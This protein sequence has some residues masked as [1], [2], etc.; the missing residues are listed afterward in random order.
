MKNIYPHSILIILCEIIFLTIDILCV[1]GIVLAI[2]EFF[3][4]YD[5]YYVLIFLSAIL[6]GV[7]SFIY[8]LSFLKKRIILKDTMIMVRADMSDK[9]GLF[10]RRLQHETIVF[11]EEIQDIYLCAAIK[12]SDGHPVKNVFVEMPYIVFVLKSGQKKFFNVYYYTKNQVANLIDMIKQ[13]AL[14]IG[15]NINIANGRELI[16]QIIN[17]KWH[18]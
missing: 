13:N 9:Y 6:V 8:L 7:T 1:I 17:E 5:W 3:T 11:Y 12:D 14:L 2:I 10:L 15:N 16:K 4:T 18:E